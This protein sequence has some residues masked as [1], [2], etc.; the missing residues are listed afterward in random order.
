MI[1]YQRGHLNYVSRETYV[2][3]NT[4]YSNVVVCFDIETTSAW[5]VDGVPQVFDFSKDSSFYDDK[6]PVALC[7][8]WQCS[9]DGKVYYGR[10][11]E[12]FYD[13]CQEL[14]EKISG[15]VTI[16]VHNLAYEF[17]FLLNIFTFDKIFARTAHK[18]IYADVER[19]RFR[20]S[21]FLTRLS[22]EAW[23]ES[24]GV[25]KLTG[26]LDY[27]VMR[28]P[29]TPLTLEEVEYC[30]YDCLVMD[31]GIRKYLDKYKKMSKI[32]LTQT[33][34]V[35]QAVKKLYKNNQAYH[36]A[37]TNILPRNAAEYARLKECF[38]GGYTHANYTY[39]G[40]I[41]KNVRSKD[42]SSSYPTA[43]IAKKYP[44]SKWQKVTDWKS[45]YDKG[46]RYSLILD[47]EFT[48]I[49]SCLFNNYLSANKPYVLKGAVKDNGRVS[50]ADTLAIVITNIDY[51]I[52]ERAYT[53]QAMSVKNAW[54]SVNDY[55]DTAFVNYILEL[56]CNK[57]SLKG[58]EEQEELYMQS[59]QFI[60]SMYGMMVTAILQ[61]NVFFDVENGWSVEELTLE[62]IDDGLNKLRSKPFKNFLA[63]QWGVFVTA[64]SRNFIWS[65]IL[66][67][68]MDKDVIYCDTDSIKYVGNHEQIFDRYN[69]GIVQELE[70]ACRKHGIDVEKLRPKDKKGIPHQ[71]GIF[72]TEPTYDEFVTLGAKRYAYKINGKIGMTV[73]GVNK[74]TGAQSLKNDLNNFK[75]G[76]LIE[77]KHCKRLIST[78]IDDMQEVIYPDGYISKYKFGINMKP[79]T[80]H[81][82][83]A[84]DYLNL[85]AAANEYKSN[86]TDYTPQEL[87]AVSER[88]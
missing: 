83:V 1:L 86:F 30:K 80:Y 46:D 37:V 40:S 9:V 5:I 36:K 15:V 52:I 29:L 17:Q 74:K 70:K 18:V 81:M 56:Y 79:S 14:Q 72:D 85:L 21:Y 69:E 62:G 39:A 78:Y 27:N 28:T 13:F 20:C 49:E 73:S 54:I 66:S 38:A 87:H 32:P 88:K 16:W 26:N 47:I 19:L 57:T 4:E 8:I 6:E 55:L 51:S 50:Y 41:L 3:R 68:K 65:V 7:Y 67:E 31:A 58:I 77:Y 12:G 35:R 42:V 64:Y 10:E 61:E 45:Y 11:L 53:W 84:D 22:L 48:Q 34:E 24:C 44:M 2:D 60:N 23:G 63:Y 75:D 76:L 82:G 59:K 71:I 33:G 25:H 43:M